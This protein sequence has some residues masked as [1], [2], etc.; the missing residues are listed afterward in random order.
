MKKDWIAI[1]KKKKRLRLTIKQ[2]LGHYWVTLFLLFIGFLVGSWNL[3][4][5]YVI[6]T[7]IDS[8]TTEELISA[9]F[10]FLLPALLLAFV[11]YQQLKFKKINLT[12]TDEQ[13]QEA[14]KRTVNELEWQI[15]Q[16]NETF[17]RAYRIEAN[18]GEMLTII[19]DKDYLLINSI[20]IDSVISYGW[21]KKN[22]KIF[23]KNLFAVLNGKPAE[24]E[25]GKT[26]DLNVKE[27]TLKKIL[28]RLILYPFCLFLVGFG[29]YILLQYY[30]DWRRWL[31]G[32]GCICFGIFYLYIDIKIIITKIN[33]Q[34]A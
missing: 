6:N 34:K 1:M 33:N 10:V 19:R 26:V 8:R 27:W 11:L 15:E 21:N 13:F 9:S 30:E 7:Y 12:L 28:I 29:I 4:E 22:I 31:I 17:F 20:G 2:T 3:I 23:L 32:V 25:I 24:K 18:T 5:I 14:V 16:N